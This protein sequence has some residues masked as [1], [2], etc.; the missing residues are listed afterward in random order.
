MFAFFAAGTKS[1]FSSIV[2]GTEIVGGYFLLVPL[3]ISVLISYVISGKNTSI[4][5][6]NLAGFSVRKKNLNKKRS[7]YQF[8]VGDTMDPTF[9]DITKEAVINEA[10]RIMKE[11][12]STV[13]AVTNNEDKLEG[14]IH[15]RDLVETSEENKEIKTVED[16]MIKDPPFL[17]P[18]DT[19]QKGL[20]TM[21]T[22]G[23]SELFVVSP[24][25]N[26]LV[27]GLISL[28]DISRMCNER[29]PILLDIESIDQSEIQETNNSFKKDSS[30]L[31]RKIS[32]TNKQIWSKLKDHW[33]I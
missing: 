19:L 23:L 22:S 12:E 21:V 26:R 6:N 11:T 8:R 2:M 33:T 7:L 31:E 16:V 28:D 30:V 15:Y 27:I 20:E 24:S 3:T 9:Y 1:P 29:K 4:Y 5:K 14:I 32:L 13:M 25:D 18:S 17:L 10:I